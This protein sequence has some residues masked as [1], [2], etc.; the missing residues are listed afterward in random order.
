MF[1]D[2]FDDIFAGFHTASMVALVSEDRL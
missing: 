1:D 2:I